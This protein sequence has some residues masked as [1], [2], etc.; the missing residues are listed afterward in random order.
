MTY[1]ND[2]GDVGPDDV[3]L[4][5]GKGSGWAASSRPGCRSR[6]DLC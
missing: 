1:I 4:A 3:A 2:L 5:G 6:R